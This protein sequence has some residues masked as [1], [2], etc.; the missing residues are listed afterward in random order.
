[1]T[2]SPDSHQPELERALRSLHLPLDPDLEHQAVLIAGD[3]LA[4][5]GVPRGEFAQHVIAMLSEWKTADPPRLLK[6][7]MQQLI[8]QCGGVEL[9]G[10]HKKYFKAHRNLVDSGSLSFDRARLLLNHARLVKHLIAQERTSCSQVARI[11][12]AMTSTDAYDWK[13][14]KILS[15]YLNVAI[16]NMEIEDYQAI[17]EDDLMGQLSKFADASQ[18]EEHQILVATATSLGFEGDSS[19]IFGSVLDTTFSPNLMCVLHLILSICERFDHPPSVI[20]EFKP[21]GNAAKYLQNTNPR[22]SSGSAILNIAKA[23]SSLDQ[24][25]AWGRMANIRN[26]AIALAKLLEHLEAMPFSARRELA[27]W[28]RQWIVRTNYRDSK[29]P[30]L[31]PGIDSPQKASELIEAVIDE[32][33]H[34][35]GAIEQRVVDSLSLVCHPQLVWKDHGRKDSVHASNLSRRKL[36]DCEYIHKSNPEIVAYEAHAGRLTKRYM[37]EHFG[38]LSMVLELRNEDLESR[39]NAEEWHIVVRYVA[40]ELDPNIQPFSQQ[41]YRYVVDFEAITFAQLYEQS[42]MFAHLSLE[43]S[44]NDNIIVALNER[45]VPQEF[46]DTLADIALLDLKPAHSE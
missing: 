44:V 38:S 16:P 46:R 32:E 30:M 41:F 18:L 3:S 37:E 33:T 5:E 24:G 20:Y 26:D 1:M 13:Q 28:L 27:S 31:L 25:W 21:R 35:A 12:S 36:G 6:Q 7:I 19:Q 34:T 15:K 22:Y 29:P 17:Y 2:I 8:L 10:F 11:L 14:I 40:H 45:S 43:G 4:N 23:T 42:K 9:D 39:A